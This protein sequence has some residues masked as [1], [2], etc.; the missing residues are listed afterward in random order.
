MP[1]P[2]NWLDDPAALFSFL[3]SRKLAAGTGEIL[4]A[5]TIIDYL[6]VNDRMPKT[7]EEAA[8]WLA[9]LICTTATEQ[10]LL[11]QLLAEY[12]SLSEHAEPS[13]PPVKLD[14]GSGPGKTKLPG[15]RWSWGWV[16]AALVSI[17]VIIGLISL[18]GNNTAS[19]QQV[20]PSVPLSDIG[21]ALSRVLDV[22]R[23]VD[24]L[25]FAVLPWVAWLLFLF[26]YRRRPVVLGREKTRA[27]AQT[28]IPTREAGPNQPKLF[29]ATEL[30]RPLQAMRAHRQ[31][32]SLDYD[33]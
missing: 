29:A 25:R 13:P 27:D 11:P 30:R 17:P 10:A 21:S 20:L 22:S 18:L 14:I 19:G 6:S 24:G 12:A 26:W 32:L 2:A 1:T 23:I 7:A 4:R 28:K 8:L 33:F 3:R 9:P 16:I 15:S 5:S 31:V